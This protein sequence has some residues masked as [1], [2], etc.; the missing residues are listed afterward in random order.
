MKHGHV[1]VGFFAFSIDLALFGLYSEFRSSVLAVDLFGDASELVVV[2]D[3]AGKVVAFLCKV[4]QCL[5][6]TGSQ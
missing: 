3:V 6:H 5:V 2:F 1:L 4:S